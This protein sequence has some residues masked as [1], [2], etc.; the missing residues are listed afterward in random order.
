MCISD[1]PNHIYYTLDIRIFPLASL[2][3]AGEFSGMLFLTCVREIALAHQLNVLRGWG[4]GER[5]QGERVAEDG[6]DPWKMDP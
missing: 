3:C 6:M 2:N 5:R 4:I 1:S